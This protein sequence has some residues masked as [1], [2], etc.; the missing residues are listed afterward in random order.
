M[1][2]SSLSEELQADATSR[3]AADPVGRDPYVDLIRAFSLLVVVIWHWLF[4]ILNFTS[5]GP[6]ATSP[7]Q[8]TYALWPLTWVLQ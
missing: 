8:W 1:E 3:E 6:R 2:T 5:S 4:T 7:L